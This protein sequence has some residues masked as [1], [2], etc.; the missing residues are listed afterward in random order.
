MN[1]E[2]LRPE[3]NL[4]RRRLG[5]YV[6]IMNG[7]AFSLSVCL[8]RFGCLVCLGFSLLVSVFFCFWFFVSCLSICYLL[9]FV[10]FVP[11]S[12]F[13]LSLFFISLCSSCFYLTLLFLCLFTFC[14]SAFVILAL[15]VTLSLP[16]LL[17]LRCFQY[18]YNAFCH[19]LYWYHQCHCYHD[20][21][22][23]ES[24][25]DKYNM[26]NNVWQLYILYQTIRIQIQKAYL[27][28]RCV[29]LYCWKIPCLAFGA[30]IRGDGQ[31]TPWLSHLTGSTFRNYKRPVSGYGATASLSRWAV[32]TWC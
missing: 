11:F 18:S 26:T 16:L 23:N 20:S 8:G 32:L 9:C 30:L 31:P 6:V 21:D 17:S 12:S 28:I 1:L 27:P 4:L 15:S 7:L 19:H 22:D 5:K 14:L 13:G 2:Q 29:W 10:S 24:N 25:N 3:W